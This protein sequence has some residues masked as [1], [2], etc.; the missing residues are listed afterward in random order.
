M[1]NGQE[2][3]E[4]QTHQK[5]SLR[6]AKSNESVEQPSFSARRNRMDFNEFINDKYFNKT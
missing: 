2:I 4:K 5:I 3:N 6:C 1:K